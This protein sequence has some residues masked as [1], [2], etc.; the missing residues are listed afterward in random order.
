MS[1]KL[2]RDDEIDPRLGEML[3]AL[4]PTPQRD[5]QTVEESKLRYLAELVKLDLPE[6]QTLSMWLAGWQSN[7]QK[8]KEILI[9]S[10]RKLAKTTVITLIIVFILLF[11]GA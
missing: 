5:P 10:I 4:R 2:Y 6:K 8:L 1:D 9:M 7:I 11:G 3:D